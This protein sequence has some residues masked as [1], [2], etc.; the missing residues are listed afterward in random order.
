LLRQIHI[1]VQGDCVYNHTYA[2]A[3]A[4]DELDNVIKIIQSYIEM[5]IHGKIFHR[6]VSEHFQ[7]FHKSE[8]NVQLI[9]LTVLTI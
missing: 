1:F 7:I 2:L 6:P 9:W 8:G 3:L 4:E 5:P